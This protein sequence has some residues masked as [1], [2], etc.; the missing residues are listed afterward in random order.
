M[1][2]L[3]RKLNT[4]LRA[5]V[6]DALTV[7]QSERE[8]SAPSGDAVIQEL[9]K[10]IRQNRTRIDDALAYE[11][12]LNAQIIQLD[13]DVRRWSAELDAAI[14]RDDD[15]AARV[16][17]EQ[18]QAGENRLVRQQHDLQEHRVVTG[19]LI[20]RVSEAERKLQALREEQAQARA[21]QPKTASPAPS[22]QAPQEA[23]TS[24]DAP[25]SAAHHDQD[26]MQA[27]L[28]RLSKR[29]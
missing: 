29:A 12:K 7:E 11:D 22:A 5:R 27:R 1:V 16:L 21:V 28:D 23:L 10:L 13:G 3:F 9:E 15:H 20:E 26:S 18:V 25:E 19:E 6:L 17:A 8:S 14:L 2:D 24:E 4:L